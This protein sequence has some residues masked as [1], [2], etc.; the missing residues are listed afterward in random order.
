MGYEIVITGAAEADF[1]EAISYIAVSLGNP[2][3]AGA[4]ADDYESA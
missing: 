3:A 4:L 2:R 1:D